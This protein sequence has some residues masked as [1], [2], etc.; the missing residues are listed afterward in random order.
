MILK[1]SDLHVWMMLQSK[2][3][4]VIAQKILIST[5]YTY[6]PIL[7]ANTLQNTLNISEA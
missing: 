4:T 5:Q 6:M 2:Y 7:W 3:N 1:N